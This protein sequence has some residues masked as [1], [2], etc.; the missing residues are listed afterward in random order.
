MLTLVGMGLAFDN[1]GGVPHAV[2][3]RFLDNTYMISNTT[4]LDERR[5]LGTGVW[6]DERHVLTNCH[7]AKMF[8]IITLH[9]ITLEYYSEWDPVTIQNHNQTKAFKGEVVACDDDLDLALIKSYWPNHDA[10]PVKLD[11]RTPRF[12]SV[13]YSAGYHFGLPLSPKQG[14]MGKTHIIDGNARVIAAMSL[15]PGDSGSPI[16][17]RW[18]DMVAMVSAIMAA[19]TA[20]GEVIQQ[21]EIGIAIPGISIATFLE[22]HMV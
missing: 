2:T 1:R 12:G 20:Y 14:L 17:N 8:E 7:V 18:G 6:I 5:G 15:G 10:H 21:A 3:E 22:E 13:I 4:V 11:W 19:S 9:D 16:F